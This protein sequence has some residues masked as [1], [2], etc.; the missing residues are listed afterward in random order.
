MI[1]LKLSQ[2]ARTLKRGNALLLKLLLLI[3]GC[4]LNTNVNSESTVF[5]KNSL[6]QIEQQYKNQPFLMII[7]MFLLM[8]QIRA[9][10][11]QRRIL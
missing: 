9:A 11:S 7:W 1:E 5:N 3:S 8:G 10:E 4:L 6:Q 2:L